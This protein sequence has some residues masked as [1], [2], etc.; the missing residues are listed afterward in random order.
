[1]PGS[2]PPPPSS[3][4]RPR[5]LPPPRSAG[6]PPPRRPPRPCPPTPSQR[7]RGPRSRPFPAAAAA[8]PSPPAAA[9]THPRPPQLRAP[10]L[11][12][13]HSAK[14]PR[15]PVLPRRPGELFPAIGSAA[16]RSGRREATGG[17]AGERGAGSSLRLGR[18]RR[19]ASSAAAAAASRVRGSAAMS[20]RLT[21]SASLAA[22]PPARP[23]PRSSLRRRGG[24]GPV[25]PLAAPRHSAL[26]PSFLTLF[27][28]SLPLSPGRQARARV[29]EARGNC[30]A[31]SVG[32]FSS[33]PALRPAGRGLRAPRGSGKSAAAGRGGC[34]RRPEPFPAAPSSVQQ[35]PP[36]PKAP[37][38]LLLGLPGGWG[39]LS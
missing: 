9:A 15:R 19:A 17:R 37:G 14:A 38:Q 5:P 30:G 8:R 4:R 29:P 12:P 26:Q 35:P 28:P 3:P 11:R 16:G 7:R 13:A 10:G 20:A 32:W 24:R 31:P 6:P 34:S 21:L 39:P 2:R 27:S 23:Q 22:C 36:P 25:P 1:M 33:S 18:R